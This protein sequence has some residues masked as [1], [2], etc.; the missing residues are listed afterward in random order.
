[1]EQQIPQIGELFRAGGPGVN[2]AL[3]QIQGLPQELQ[4]DL[5][6]QIGVAAGASGLRQQEGLAQEERVFERQERA[7]QGSFERGLASASIQQRRAQS[8]KDENDRMDALVE[9]HAFEQLGELPAGSTAELMS[10]LQAQGFTESTLRSQIESLGPRRVAELSRSRRASTGEAE[11]VREGDDIK[12]QERF[13]L[14]R[15]GIPEAEADGIVN[16]IPDAV[17]RNTARGKSAWD[18]VARRDGVYNPVGFTDAAEARKFT[19]ARIAQIEFQDLVPQMRETWNA[20]RDAT[21]RGETTAGAVF[22]MDSVQD[23]FNILGMQDPEVAA[24]RNMRQIMAS[25]VLKAVQGSRPS[26]FDFRMYLALF[27][28]ATE[29]VAKSAEAK[30][31]LFEKQLTIQMNAEALGRGAPRAKEVERIRTQKKTPL[32]LKLERAINAMSAD[33]DPT[34]SGVQADPEA[35]R[36]FE[37]VLVEWQQKR[38]SQF[39]T[40]GAR[41]AQRSGGAPVVSDRAESAAAELDAFLGQ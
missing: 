5:L 28:S 8:Q 4:A 26:D 33:G 14:V 40:A 10:T 19:E 6:S 12:S 41:D 13:N 11:T 38:G 16:A 21:L 36:E 2:Q 3:N 37:K 25:K 20:L 30:L 29:A 39:L 35:V 24:W 32:D 15:S 7:A 18:P 31:D 34:R 17:W 1:V 27:P 9:T 22:G 23:F